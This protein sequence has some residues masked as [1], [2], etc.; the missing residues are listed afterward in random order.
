MKFSAHSYQQYATNR[1]LEQQALG[2][3]LDMGLGKTVITLTAIQ[4][5]LYDL[6]EVSRVLVIAPLRVAQ[7]TWTDEARKWDHLDL[8]I[9]KVLGSRAQRLAALEVQADVYII[10][11]ENVSWL[12]EHY[13][14]RWPFDMVVIDELSS[15]KSTKAKR[16]RDLRKVRPLS[17]R[18]VGLT[19]TPAPNGL[20]DLWPQVYLLDRGERLGKTV[21]AYRERYF[22]PGKRNGH[23]VYEWKLKDW[24]EDAIYHALDDLCVSMKSEDYLEMPDR[25]ENEI[26]VILDDKS[27]RQYRQL[28]KELLLPF[29]SGDVV[30][31]TA[32]VLSTKLQQLSNGAIYNEDHGVQHIHDAKIKALEELIEE[33]QGKPLLVFYWFK[34]DRHRLLEAFPEAIT[35]QGD[36]DIKDWNAG[37]IPLLLVHPASAGHGLNLQAGGSTI[38]WFGLTWSL[39]LYQQANARLYRQGQEHTVVIHHLITQGTIDEQII[40]ALHTKSVTQDDL[41]AAVKARIADV[42]EI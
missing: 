29:A 35:L 3:F 15:F 8:R 6:F 16:F 19:G 18:I 21:S 2:L 32:A 4:D 7:S 36:N 33:S 22:L 24:A 31:D 40:K 38:I 1:I 23:I 20:L 25:I 37:R 5:L 14:K 17:S 10:N 30:A 12:V 26:P 39:E 11:R 13:Q 34:H 9:G 28:E 42:V 27:R 41:I